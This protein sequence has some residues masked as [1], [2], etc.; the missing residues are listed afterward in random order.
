MK[1][2]PADDCLGYLSSQWKC[3][4]CDIWACPDCHVAK[5]FNR[6]EPHTCDPDTLA[7]ARLIAQDTKACPNCHIDIYK[8]DG[9]NQMWCVKC[10]TAFD[11]RTLRIETGV[12]HNPHY[13]QYMRETNNGVVPRNPMDHPCGGG[14]GG[15][16]M[17]NAFNIHNL[18]TVRSMMNSSTTNINT[19]KHITLMA[20]SLLHLLH[21]EMPAMQVDYANRNLELRIKYLNR[22]I[23][24]Q[25]FKTQLQRGEKRFEKKHAIYQI[26]EMVTNTMGDIISGFIRKCIETKNKYPRLTE[27]S[28]TDASRR[29]A[30]MLSVEWVDVILPQ[31]NGIRTY[32]NECLRQIANTFSAKILQID[33]KL[34]FK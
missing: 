16:G 21:Y 18:H 31:I 27:N 22:E 11:W 7:T 3:G 4:T 28:H 15:D 5:G 34:N 14:G 8:I 9:C 13:F 12:V 24:E 19:Y 30:D 29:D 23:S 17:Q 25:D 1:K 32:S 10:F 6:D 2:C 20:R 33:D 26:L